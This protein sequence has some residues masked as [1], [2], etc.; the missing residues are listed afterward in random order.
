MALAGALMQIKEIAQGRISRP[1]ADQSAIVAGTRLDLAML[2]TMRERAQ[3]ARRDGDGFHGADCCNARG[4]LARA[5]RPAGLS[6]F[7]LGLSSGRPRQ[8]VSSGVARSFLGRA[9]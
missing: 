9:F 6:I 2:K 1:R 8:L 7:G 3:P 5:R 4:A